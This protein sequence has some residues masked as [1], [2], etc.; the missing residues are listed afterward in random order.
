M[1]AIF[2]SLEE[3]VSGFI[4]YLTL[5]IDI[6]AGIIIGVAIVVALNFIPQ[7]FKKIYDGAHPG[8]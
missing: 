8:P 6:I 2:G 3:F 5:G 7:K 1:E 4:N